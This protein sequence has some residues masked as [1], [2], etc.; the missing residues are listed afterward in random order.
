VPTVIIAEEE[1][2]LRI[3]GDSLMSVRGHREDSELAGKRTLFEEGVLSTIEGEAI[4]CK[5]V[6]DG[7]GLR[8]IFNRSADVDGCSIVDRGCGRGR[9]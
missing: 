8:K 4:D 1:M 3:D 7:R 6:G 2:I 9:D 5:C